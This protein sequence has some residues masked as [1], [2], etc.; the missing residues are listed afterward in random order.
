MIKK[1]PQQN[2]QEIFDFDG[3]EWVSWSCHE[4][5][6][7]CLYMPVT[8]TGNISSVGKQPF[9][10]RETISLHTVF[11]VSLWSMILASHFLDIYLILLPILDID[12]KMESLL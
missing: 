6:H 3:N 12:F 1:K 2:S 4:N 7:D 9:G 8:K 11:V 10:S 5:G